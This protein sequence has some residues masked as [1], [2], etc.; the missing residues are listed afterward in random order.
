[1]S[2]PI[3]TWCWYCKQEIP[4]T[5]VQCPSC[6]K[7]LSDATKVIRCRRCGKFLLK[8]AERCLQCGEIMQMPEPPMAPPMEA[9]MDA[10]AP[11][12]PAE[13]AVPEDAVGAPPTESGIEFPAGTEGAAPPMGGAVPIQFPE[14]APA[15]GAPGMPY[16][17][18]PRNPAAPQQGGAAP[19]SKKTLL[20]IVIAAVALIVLGVGIFFGVKLIKAKKADAKPKYCAENEHQW[21]EADCTK[22]KTCSV[23]GMTEGEPGAHQF[24][25]NVCVV[26]GAYERLFYLTDSACDRDGSD[27]VFSG[28]VQNFAGKK[29]KSI[30]IKVQLYDE[31]KNIVGTVEGEPI[32]GKFAPLESVDWELHYEKS[33]VKWKYW[34]A[35][36]A[37]YAPR[38]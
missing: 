36:V 30:T 27:V 19:K 37:D 13:Q 10:G 7:P 29:V 38:D 24:V 26:C 32:E 17:Y 11:E 5:A 28:K 21:V 18:M 2:Q 1:M 35:Y 34:R 33:G 4:G 15:V 3:P 16:P 31:E 14:P 25:D 12:T 20:L 8:N 23:C 9:P 22:P 6:G